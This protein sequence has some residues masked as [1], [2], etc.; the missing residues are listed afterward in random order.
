MDEN[1]LGQRH[2]MSRRLRRGRR[3]AE[4]SGALD[5][6]HLDALRIALSPLTAMHDRH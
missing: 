5:A 6:F 1:I 4:V 2:L 3:E